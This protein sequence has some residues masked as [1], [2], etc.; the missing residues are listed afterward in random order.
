MGALPHE[1]V[2]VS[3]LESDERGLLELGD[4]TQ[5]LPDQG[6][7]RCVF[8]ERAGT[9][10]RYQIVAAL[11]Q[12][13]SRFEIKMPD[14]RRECGQ[15]SLECRRDFGRGDTNERKRNSEIE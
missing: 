14:R 12:S 4:R 6:R 10:N 13:S 11:A 9:I 7:S 2:P 1:A 5:Y 15:I 8:E 3:K